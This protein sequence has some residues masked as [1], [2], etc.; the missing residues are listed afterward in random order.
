M[1][2][3]FKQTRLAQLVIAILAFFGPALTAVSVS[4]G[5]PLS[6]AID[7]LIAD[8]ADG[9]L[10]ARSDDAEFLRRVTL[11]FAGHIPTAD[12]VRA[13]IDDPSA[14]KRSKLIDKLLAADTFAEQCADRLSVMLLERRR[15]SG[16]C[17]WAWI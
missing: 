6:A 17:C 9:P 10:A 2:L 3:D 16:A 1:L 7:R 13:F 12:G 4:A 11:D 8:G 15:I 5:E 14:D